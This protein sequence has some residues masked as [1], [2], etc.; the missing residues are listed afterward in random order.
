VDAHRPVGHR[1]H[2]SVRGGLPE[3]ED[4]PVLAQG[5]KAVPVHIAPGALIRSHPDSSR[6]SRCEVLD[7]SDQRPVG[8]RNSFHDL[9]APTQQRVGC[10]KPEGS[11]GI[12][13]DM[14][15]VVP[16][17]L[18][19]RGVAAVEY[20]KSPAIEPHQTSGC[21]QPEVAVAGLTNGVNPIAG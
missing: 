17:L 13:D 21:S 16:R 4:M 2:Q 9:P 1:Y 8:A 18:H 19:R 15:H 6:L 3:H 12:F 11:R 7:G 14:E 10:G 20:T 5:S